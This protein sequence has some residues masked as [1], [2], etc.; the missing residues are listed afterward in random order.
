MNS[1]KPKS[2]LL[3]DPELEQFINDRSQQS[4]ISQL[5]A[6]LGEAGNDILHAYS[7]QK[8]DNTFY[9]NMT[10]NSQSGQELADKYAL[11]Q[12]QNAMK[13]SETPSYSHVQIG[14]D[15]VGFNQKDPTDQVVIGPAP[16][17]EANPVTLQN[18]QSRQTEQQEKKIEKL[19]HDLGNSQDI[20]Y[21]VKNIEDSLG[22]NLE[23]YDP[24]TKTVNGQNIDLPGISVPIVGRVTEYSQEATGLESKMSKLFNTELH[25]RSGTAVT[26]PE[27][28][29]LRS[30]FGTG[31]YN[32]EDQMLSAMKNYKSALK[33]A[34]TNV[35]AR[36]PKEVVQEYSSRGGL[37][38]GKI[39]T[40]ASVTSN[41]YFTGDG[42]HDKAL[43]NQTA[44]KTPSRKIKI[45]GKTKYYQ[46]GDGKYYT[47]PE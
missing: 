44:P 7:P 33:N 11:A 21:T 15:I 28:E 19:G 16:P 1:F 29:R 20:A 42:S 26:T 17:K 23:A 35:E 31:K 43:A 39:P 38:T 9:Q 22:F 47:S 46:H 2:P 14:N 45:I 12:Q 18:A 30:E 24:S 25:D 34:M 41:K 6:G 4:N 36:Y 3:D 40:N 10:K 13:K 5:I 32:T 27:L 8:A 37:T